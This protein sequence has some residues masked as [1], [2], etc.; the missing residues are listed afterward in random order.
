MGGI[1]RAITGPS[2]AEKKAKRAR[3]AQEVVNQKRAAA[4]SKLKKETEL[5]AQA[6]GQRA[7]RRAGRRRTVFTSP[8]GLSE[9]GTDNLA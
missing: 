9:N 3:Q 6:K 5:V 2:A 1:V 4:A 8:L 7:Q